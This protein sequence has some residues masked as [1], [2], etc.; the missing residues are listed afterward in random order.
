[1]HQLVIKRFQHLYS[2]CRSGFLNRWDLA[3][4]DW[5]SSFR[6]WNYIYCNT[7]VWVRVNNSLLEKRKRSVSTDIFCDFLTKWPPACKA[8]LV[9]NHWCILCRVSCLF[10]PQ[11]RNAVKFSALLGI[12]EL[13]FYHESPLKEDFGSVSTA[14]SCSD[15]SAIFPPAARTGLIDAYWHPFLTVPN[16]RS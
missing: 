1:M 4:D 11:S 6:K 9:H 3:A 5:K 7:N 14:E 13:F 12:P 10:M 16:S 8:T 2:V 15:L